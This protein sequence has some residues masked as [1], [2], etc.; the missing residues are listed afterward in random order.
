MFNG[1][2]AYFPIY[3]KPMVDVKKASLTHQKRHIFW[4]ALFRT[5]RDKF[6]VGGIIKC[7]HDLVQLSSPMIFK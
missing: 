3:F 6:I 7:I 2:F 5:Y 1:L 4:H